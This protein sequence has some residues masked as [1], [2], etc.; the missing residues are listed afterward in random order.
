MSATL[1]TVKMLI[2]KLQEFPEDM[3]VGVVSPLEE[4]DAKIE[5]NI[6][7][8]SQFEVIKAWEVRTGWT[9]PPETAPTFGGE[10]MCTDILLLS[11]T[12]KEYL[13]DE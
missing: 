10:D 9:Y 5:G 8:I 13:E 1:I 11:D 7:G 2:S 6:E 3:L 12:G 4:S